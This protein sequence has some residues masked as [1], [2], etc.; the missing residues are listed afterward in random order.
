MLIDT[1][2]DLMK[3]MDREQEIMI[4]GQSVPVDLMTQREREY[5]GQFDM[6]QPPPIE[7]IWR[8]MDKAWDSLGLSSGSQPGEEQLANFYCHP[9]WILNG[10]FSASDP[11]SSAN[12]EA[13]AKMVFELPARNIAD[14]GGGMGELAI[15]ISRMNPDRHIEII[16][17]YP[18]ELGRHRIT[19][20]A[21]ISY[22]SELQGPYDLIIAQDVLEH[23]GDP[24]GLVSQ[25][26]NASAVGG[27]LIFANC[28]YPVIKCHL[29]ATFHL[30]ETFGWVAKGAGLEYIGNVTGVEHASIFR[31][32]GRTDDISLR[33]REL[34]SK[35][36]YYVKNG[37]RMLAARTKNL[38]GRKG[39]SQPGPESRVA[40]YR[41]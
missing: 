22:V 8:E 5:L 10:L 1:Q 21:N 29:P 4:W 39:K 28:F 34:I 15:R 6:G 9:V 32:T 26:S 31:K 20:Y 24:V 41:K 19:R 23:L 13:I 30:R 25:L 18:S 17:P 12:R 37:V 36:M 33:T 11:Q 16:E 3:T 2:L 38:A 35:V 7:E 27:Y 14:Y 40:G